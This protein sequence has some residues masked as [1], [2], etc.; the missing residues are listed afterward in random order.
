MMSKAV[1]V[2]LIFAGIIHLLP[3]SGVL[4]ADR[5]ATLYGM[6]FDEPN[7]LILMRSR[8]VLFGLLGALLLYAAFHP[9]LQPI[10]LLGGLISVVSFLI[11]ARLSPGH[12]EA[13]QRVVIADW[14][15]LAC[16]LLALVLY[17]IAR[18]KT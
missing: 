10:A 15:A 16:L 11:L 8:A 18:V 17:C 7:L 3:L 4:G 12:N 5:L 6:T 2:L 13:L 1:S 9:P 14:G